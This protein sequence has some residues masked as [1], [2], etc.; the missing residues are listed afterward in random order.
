MMDRPRILII[1]DDSGL[2]KTLA[3]ILRLKGFEPLAAKDG[4]EGLAVLKDNPVDLVLIDLGLP[5]I[6]GIDV[7][8]Q[9][10]DDYPS[11]E[12]IIITGNATL[13]SAIEATNKGAFSYLQKP[14]DIDQLILHVRRAIENMRRKKRSGNT[15]NILRSLSGKGRRNLRSQNF[16]QMPAAAPRPNLSQT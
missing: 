15:R 2:R 7:L 4:T 6:A 10:K 1:D 9:V 3:D 16:R 5:D 8:K 12:A 13:D 11:T 14:Y